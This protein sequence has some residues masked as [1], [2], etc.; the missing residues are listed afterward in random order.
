MSAVA[1]NQTGRL[2]LAV[3]VTWSRLTLPLMTAATDAQM[4]VFHLVWT[5]AADV[6]AESGFAQQ[7][8]W[9]VLSE[10]MVVVMT[11]KKTMRTVVMMV[12]LK[13]QEWSQPVMTRMMKL[14][15]AG[16]MILTMTRLMRD[17]SRLS[18]SRRG[19]AEPAPPQSDQ[20]GSSQGPSPWMGQEKTRIRTDWIIAIRHIESRLQSSFQNIPKGYIGCFHNNEISWDKTLNGLRNSHLIHLTKL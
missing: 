19:V 9:Q 11:I 7:M 6:A 1:R 16:G 13:L 5:L 17:G 3:P 10:M 14:L 4:V 12:V 15:V 8:S 20:R 18:D 2:A